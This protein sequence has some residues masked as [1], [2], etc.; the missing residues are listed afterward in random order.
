MSGDEHWEFAVTIP[1]STPKTSPLT[2]LTRMPNRKITDITWTIPVG[3]SGFSGFRIT[4]GGVQVIPANPGAWIIRDGSISGAALA[5]LPTSGAWD[6]TGYNTGVHSHTVYVTFF[7]EVIVPPPAL[8]VPFALDE[9][10][11]GTT[12]P[13]AHQPRA[14]QS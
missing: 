10:Q 13:L 2:T 11:F 3:A 1:A 6:V 12:S 4:M 7:A 14:R 8:I 9:L 5:R